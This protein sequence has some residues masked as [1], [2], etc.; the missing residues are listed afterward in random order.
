MKQTTLVYLIQDQSWLFLFRNKKENDVNHGKWIG[1]GGKKETY[2]TI[3]ECAIRETKEETGYE[4]EELTFHGIVYFIYA[5]HEVEEM[6]VFTSNSFQGKQKECDEGILD[7][8]PINQIMDLDLWE[9]DR[10][11]LKDMIEQPNKKFIYELHY[12][13]NSKLIECKEL[14]ETYG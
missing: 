7:W 14:K 8:I 5:D 2:E 4:I 10:I 6:N 3:E 1:V 11:F 9:G 12:D 13:I